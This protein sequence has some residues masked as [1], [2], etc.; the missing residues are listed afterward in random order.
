MPHGEVNEIIP[1]KSADVFALLHDYDRRLEWDTLL[2]AAYLTD[3]FTRAEQGVISTCV[4]RS[5]VGA[6]ALT[7]QYVTF[8]PSRL[9]AVKMIRGPW[10]FESWAASIKHE[11][12]ADGSSRICYAW[13]FQV[14]PRLLRWLIGPMVNLVF[15]WETRKRLKALGAFSARQSA[16]AGTP[17][18][19]HQS[20]DATS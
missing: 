9:T 10:L 6:M 16:K 1:A 7:T 19:T 2:Q 3:G 11:D 17:T 5:A 18:S 12:L 15:Y 14:R 20:S 8:Q 4:G 13:Q